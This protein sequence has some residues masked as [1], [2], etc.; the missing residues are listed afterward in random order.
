MSARPA[1]PVP[2]EERIEDAV[3]ELMRERDI[4]EITAVSVCRLAGV[5]R[6]TFYR[7]FR[8]VDDVVKRFEDRILATMQVINSGALRFRSGKSELDP[9]AAMIER[10]EFLSAHRSKLIALT[11]PHGDPQFIHKTVVFMHQHFRERLR[12]MSPGGDEFD[13]YLSFV[14]AGHDNLIQYWL[15]ER[16]DLEPRFVAAVLNRLF[17][18]PFFIGEE[19]ALALPPECKLL[20]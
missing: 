11:G 13:L 17:Y 12:D 7:H 14:I 4:P 2:V 1:P 20:L 3:F 6:A 19:S 15:E 8:S 18:A 16:P 5:S 9:S 10:M